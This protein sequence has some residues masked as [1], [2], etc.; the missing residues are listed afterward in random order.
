MRWWQQA[1][2]QHQAGWSPFSWTVYADR[3]LMVSG[4]SLPVL[5]IFQFSG[6]MNEWQLRNA[7]QQ[8]RMVGWPACWWTSLEWSAPNHWGRI[9]NYLP[10][11]KVVGIKEAWPSVICSWVS[12]LFFA[13]F[14]WHR[15]FPCHHWGICSSH[16]SPT[17]N[18][19]DG[20]G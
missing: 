19:V 6:C 11:G 4:F 15:A 8:R 14:V 12:A 9:Y 20:G 13:V 1:T 2:A 7:A 18:K 10:Q 16:Q 5:S 17:I 3:E